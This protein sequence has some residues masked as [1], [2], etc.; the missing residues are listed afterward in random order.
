MVKLLKVF[1]HFHVIIAVHVPVWVWAYGGWV[2]TLCG[3]MACG[4]CAVLVAMVSILHDLRLRLLEIEHHSMLSTTTSSSLCIAWWGTSIDTS[5]DWIKII[6]D[7]WFQGLEIL[8]LVVTNKIYHTW[9]T[10]G[11]LEGRQNHFWS[12]RNWECAPRQSG[13][14]IKLYFSNK[15]LMLWNSK[16]EAGPPLGT[17]KHKTVFKSS[18]A[19]KQV[20]RAHW[21][22]KRG[23]F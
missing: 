23:P 3:A 19:T 12:A 21:P 11:F 18:S 2:W 9:E 10:L 7:Y 15:N 5:M 1:L 8:I 6:I 16:G 14:N 13:G 4:K 20:L 17:P 22:P